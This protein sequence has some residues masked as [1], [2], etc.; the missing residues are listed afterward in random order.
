MKKIISLLVC[1]VL[2]FSLSI[3][4]FAAGSAKVNS[5]SSTNVVKLGDTITVTVSL[6]DCAPFKSMALTPNYDKNV[7]EMV[8]GE[9]LLTGATLSNFN[10]TS[11]AIAY[12]PVVEKSG[13]IFK[14]VLKVKDNATLKNTTIKTDA[15]IKNG[16]TPVES[17]AGSVTVKVIC[18]NHSFGAWS[19]ADNNNHKHICTACDTAESSAHTWNGGAITKAATCKETGVKTYTCTVCNATKTEAIATTTNHTFGNWTQ[20]KEPTC[21]AKGTESRTCSI[22]QKVETKDIAALGHKFSD[23]TVTKEPTC[24]EEGIESGKCTRCDKETTNT[25]PKK[26]HTFGE[27]VVVTPA[28]ETAVGKQTKTCTI[29]NTVVEEEIPMLDKNDVETNVEPD[30]TVNMDNSDDVSENENSSWIIWVIIGAVII[31]GVIIII[32]VK[33]KK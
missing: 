32:V 33:K 12:T 30:D 26:E 21:T 15:V 1:L 22:C 4:V 23:P 18:K 3:S 6:S 24:S 31:G 19:I 10:G 20:T 11:A 14:Y 9:W 16:A 8:S 13:A 29:C 2:V 25:L 28:T 7:F 5:N 27:A 17:V